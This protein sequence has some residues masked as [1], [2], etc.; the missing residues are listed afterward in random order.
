MRF[1]KITLENYLSSRKSD[2]SIYEYETIILPKRSTSF[3]AGYDFFAPFDFVIKPKETLIVP[4]GIKCKLD[5]DK[6]LFIFVRSSLGIKKHISLSNGTGIIDADYYNNES[7]E[8]HILVA[9]TNYGDNE[10]LISKGQ[11][12][13]QGVITKYYLCED[14]K[15]NTTRVGGIGSTNKK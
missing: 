14:D 6:V 8:G 7:N 5:Y 12:F 10:V 11:H 1:E 9:L 3:A 2:D 13:V 15:T 4:T